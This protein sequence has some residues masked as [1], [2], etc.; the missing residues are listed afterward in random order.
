MPGRLLMNPKDAIGRSKPSMSYV[1]VPALAALSEVMRF[2]ASKYGAFNWR[3]QPVNATVY[4]NAC[5]LYTSDAA[6]E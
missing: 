1:S 3:D 2:G 6:D 5:L 4:M